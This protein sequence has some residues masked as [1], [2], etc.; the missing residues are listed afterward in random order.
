M[1]SP[2]RFGDIRFDN[3]AGE[4]DQQQD[5]A[6][7]TIGA[8]GRRGNT[9][10]VREANLRCGHMVTA[11]LLDRFILRQPALNDPGENGKNHDE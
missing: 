9:V 6:D 4:D 1:E 2:G 10:P 5:G 8:G 3:P 11:G 7:C